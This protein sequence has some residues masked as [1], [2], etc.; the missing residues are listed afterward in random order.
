MCTGDIGV[1]ILRELDSLDWTNGHQLTVT[2]NPTL[3]VKCYY[4]IRY[5][6]KL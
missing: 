1:V 2:A 3:S 5:I 4:K 6:I